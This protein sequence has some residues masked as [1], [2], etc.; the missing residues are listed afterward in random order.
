MIDK[1]NPLAETNP[2]FQTLASSYR[3]RPPRQIDSTVSPKSPPSFIMRYATTF[4]FTLLPLVAQQEVDLVKLGRETFHAVGCAECH[5]EVKD[6][7]SVK[8]GPGLYG[9][10]QKTPR[11]RVIIT[12]GEKH[13]LEVNA[14]LKYLTQSLRQPHADLAIAESG[15]TKGQPYL[16]VMPPYDG[17]FISG[18]KT[19]ALYQYLLTLNDE[20]QRGPAKLLA[21]TRGE[22]APLPAVRDPGEIL[23]TDRTRI[24][25]ARINGSSIRSAFVGTPSGLNYNFDPVSMSIERIWWGGFINIKEEQTGR[26]GKASRLGQNALEVH[27]AKPLLAPLHPETGKPIDLSFKS[28]RMM[29]FETIAKNLHSEVDFADQLKATPAHF[30]GYR[31]AETPTFHF[32]VGKNKFDLQFTATAEG[33]ATLSLKGTLANPQTF[34][35]S[36]LLQKGETWTVEKLPA[37]LSFS[38]PVHP[39]W[40]PK[41][42]TTVDSQP[43]KIDEA[44]KVRLPEGF[45]AIQ[46]AAPTDV[47]GREQLFE[48]MGMDFFS[49]DRLIVTTRTA[50]IWQ[51]EKGK[52]TLIAEGSLDS[53]G[54][55]AEDDG[56]LIIGHKPE[57]ARLRD[58]D[59]D[60]W[61]ETHEVLS[62][63]FLA[64]GNYHEYLHGPTKD[65][66]GNYYFQLNLAH[67]NKKE[68]IH[69]ANG[70]FMGAQGGYRGW[71]LRVTPEGVTTPFASGL[72]SPAGLATGPDGTLY[73][74]ENQGEYVGTS[75]LFILKEGKYYGHP[76]GLVDL[77]GMTPESPEIHWDKFHDTKERAIALMAHSRLANAPGSPA[78]A[79][80]SFGA[81]E[82]EMFVGDQT[83]SS[84]FRILPKENHESALIP[85]AD[86]FPSGVM[87]LGF[88]DDGSL[89][90]GQTGR[91]WRARGG[92]EHALISILRSSGPLAPQIADLTR[93]GSTFTIRFTAPFEGTLEK[94]EL[95]AHSYSMLDSPNYG[96]QENDRMDHTFSKLEKSPDQLSIK[97][98]VDKLPIAGKNTIIRFHSTKL[99]AT[100]GQEFEVFYT[101]VNQ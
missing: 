40:R 63:D 34:G 100:K 53:L 94:G 59:G 92:S 97:V 6:D 33:K 90:V 91:G 24:Y 36:P 57:L 71:A 68:A 78:W 81:F 83:L 44:P 61:Y 17:S 27:G 47:H 96:S 56:S 18:F 23:V 30:H 14:N 70:K 69:K 46:I 3:S 58:T 99:P 88:P 26:G 8:T 9:L 39:A 42:I 19:K 35:L 95:K 49:D 77:P 76:G 84:L 15:A 73:Y 80:S 72:R 29:G 32:S 79:S 21:K 41:G 7:P 13:R 2:L 85:F 1:N 51:L 45:K 5:S 38:I 31:H 37:T 86:G 12:G 4:L 101:L 52:W 11:K 82:G 67:H 25:R 75:K 10:F 93:E 64:T 50:G 20:D 48:P 62:S 66:S 65:K 28:P 22:H 98:T 16:P 55:I 54:V 87:R 74:T 60:G 43:S 89:F